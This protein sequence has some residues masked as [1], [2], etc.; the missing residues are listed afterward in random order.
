MM[1]NILIPEDI[2]SG[3][4]GEAALFFG[5]AKSLSVFGQHKLTLFSLHPDEDLAS[6]DK[7]ASI[8]DVHS[9]VPNHLLDG[10]GTFHSKLSN[11]IIFIG[12]C[13]AFSVLYWL[14]GSNCLRI[15]RHPAWRCFLDSDMV[16]MCHDS[17]YAPLYHGPLIF[18]FKT[19]GKPVVLFGSTILPPHT[20]SSRLERWLRNT[21]NKYFLGKSDLITL[22]EWYSYH[23]LKSLGI[24]NVFVFP[25]L[26]FIADTAED[27]DIKH[28]F[29]L[30]G[31]P[32]STP[33]CGFA[34]SQKEID[35]ACP[36]LP[37]AER[38]EYTLTCLAALL[39][40]ITG[41]LGMHAVFIPHAI[42]PTPRVDDRIAADWVRERCA[43]KKNVT[44][45]RNNYSQSQLRGM[46]KRLN[47]TVGTRLHFT[48]DALCHHVPSLLITHTGEYRCHGII[49]D[50]L[51]QDKYVYNIENITADGLIQLF[52][53]LWKN[54][55]HVKKDLT[56][57]LPS[58]MAE[59]MK[60]AL[61]AKDTLDSSVSRA[62]NI[63][64]Y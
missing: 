19:L 30:E 47:I 21:T 13:T 14:L 45:I 9:L 51:G 64:S 58:I 3:N 33:L 24:R 2:P 32:E 31:V 49:G 41:V 34:F 16:L 1:L 15:M 4:K 39:D 52:T 35:F 12:K 46:A 25:D 38:R 6:Y 40:H 27:A 26:A 61:A 62:H 20:F 63:P 44:I 60:H 36:E 11:Y 37:L 17:F 8:I 7:Y 43:N 42:G 56:Q 29:Q 55:D 10:V 57:L 54:H 18:I 50:M 23:Y 5:I 28:I 22:R 59:T 53:E 48:I